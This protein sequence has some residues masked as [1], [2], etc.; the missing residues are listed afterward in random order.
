V[1]TL[2]EAAVAAVRA[3]GDE[4]P[5]LVGLTRVRRTRRAGKVAGLFTGGTL[6]EEARAIV[7][8]AAAR[9]VD[10]GGAEFTRGRPH[11]MIDPDLR[12]AAIAATGD[13]AE[14][15]VLLLDFVLGQCA[16]PNPVGAAAAAI[17]DARGRARRAGRVLS[18]VAHVVGTD[19]DPQ[20][21]PGQELSLQTIG[22]AVHPSNRLAALAARDLAAEGRPRGRGA[23]GNGHE[24]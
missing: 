19:E 11:P 15:G 17:E 3:A 24:R 12:N 9:F 10:F 2:E 4:P 18:V 23:R 14:V 5:P 8:D 16:H 21:L 1:D 22:V 20:G 7:G 6:C 13:D